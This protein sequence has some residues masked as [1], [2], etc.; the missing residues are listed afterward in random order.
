MILIT[1]KDLL[2]KKD[3]TISEL[4]RLTGMSRSTITLIRDNKTKNIDFD[5]IA[6]LCRALSCK[7]GDIIEYIDKEE[8]GN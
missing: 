5:S 6:K 8:K 2:L 3:M 4:S 7:P 1:L